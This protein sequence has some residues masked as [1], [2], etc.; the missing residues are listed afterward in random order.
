MR[1]LKILTICFSV[2][3]F[4]NALLAEEANSCHK[5]LDPQKRLDCYDKQT[6]FEIPA[7]KQSESTQLPTQKAEAPQQEGFGLEH[8]VREKLPDELTFTVKGEFKYWYKGLIINTEDSQ[9][10][11]IKRARKTYFP[12]KNPNITIRKGSLGSYLM[13]VEGLNRTF[14]VKRLK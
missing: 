12:A 4:N 3:F 13:N 5:Q 10:W 11:V 9:K 6:G 8:K 1:S 7:K 2:I 14:K